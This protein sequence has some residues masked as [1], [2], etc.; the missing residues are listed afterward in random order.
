MRLIAAAILEGKAW[1]GVGFGL[2]LILLLGSVV[3]ISLPYGRH[4][5]YS[6]HFYTP[7]RCPE[8]SGKLASGEGLIE[9]VHR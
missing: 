3:I 8:S 1:V 9:C 2:W 6:I 4:V 7:P 5:Y